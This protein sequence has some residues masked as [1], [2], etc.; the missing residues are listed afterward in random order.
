MTFANP[1]FWL[2]AAAAGLPILLHLIQRVTSRRVRLGTVGFLDEVLCEQS[3]HRKPRRLFL[4]MLRIAAML[5]IAALFAKPF[6]SKRSTSKSTGR[7]QVILVDRSPSMSVRMPNGVRLIDVAHA[8]AVSLATAGGRDLA[9]TSFAWFDDEC[10]WIDRDA[11]LDTRR[12][13]TSAVAS[14]FGSALMAAKTRAEGIGAVCDVVMITDMQDRGLDGARDIDWPNSIPLTIIDLHRDQVEN[15]AVMDVEMRSDATTNAR[16]PDVASTR[17]P[18]MRMDGFSLPRRSP[19]D[20]THHAVVTLTRTSDLVG[21]EA[22]L[23]VD[24]VDLNAAGGSKTLRSV[25]KLIEWGGGDEAETTLNLGELPAGQYAVKAVCEIDDDFVTDNWRETGLWVGDAIRVPIVLMPDETIEPTFLV[26]ALSASTTTDSYEDRLRQLSTDPKTRI[27]SEKSQQRFEPTVVP[28]D[29]NADPTG[30]VVVVVNPTADG[31]PNNAKVVKFI[32]DGGSVVVFLGDRLTDG[33]STVPWLP[34][35][36]TQLRVAGFAPYRITT[37]DSTD[38]SLKAFDDFQVGN[39]TRLAFSRVVALDREAKSADVLASFE[40]DL[41]AISR[42]KLGKGFVVWC[43][44]LPVRQWGPFVTHRL[45][46]PLL[47]QLVGREA[48]LTGDGPVRVHL[49]GDRSSASA[50][51][52]I[53]QGRTIEVIQSP[54]S[55]SD[56]TFA[57]MERFADAMGIDAKALVLSTTTVT[58]NRTP[59][60]IDAPEDVGD[61]AA[62][63][64]GGKVRRS[65][66]PLWRYLAVALIGL[67]FA[68]SLVAARTPA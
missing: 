59:D 3:R 26:A 52:V 58:P 56:F 8:R 9:E 57:S 16:E 50:P 54:T 25:R 17:M 21:G 65:E 11:F 40:A 7:P 28:G 13:T 55:E 62:I 48:G 61:D 29:W 60:R 45:F 44:F 49:A 43:S 14:D 27:S 6:L 10:R 24:V 32:M 22:S 5:L 12:A 66:Q 64:S 2:A 67:L 37:L 46:T 34:G 1:I 19:V 36:N 39:L 18:S 4:L 31:G 41:P 23:L 30:D 35:G 15:V 42:R 53:K 63:G 20:A 47:Q 68:E 38:E 51:S 33:E